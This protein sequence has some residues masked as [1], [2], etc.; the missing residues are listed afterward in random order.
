MEPMTE[1][2][3]A[4]ADERTAIRPWLVGIGILSLAINALAFVAP[5][6]M[7][8]VFDRVLTSGRI[9]TLVY[10]TLLA[11][12]ALMVLGI[13][14]GARSQALAR[15]GVWLEA[16]LSRRALSEVVNQELRHARPLLDVQSVRSFLASPAVT[17]FLDAPAVPLF[18]AVLWMIHPLFGAI[19]AGTAITL[20]VIAA[21]GYRVGKSP[22]NAASKHRQDA[23]GIA[24]SAIRMTD[25][26]RALGVLSHLLDRFEDVNA[27]GLEAQTRSADL[28]SWF[29]GFTKSF[30]I[31]IQVGILGVGAYLVIG[32]ELTGGGMIAASIMLGRALAPV[33]QAAGAWKG[34]AS[35][36]ASYRSLR[37]VLDAGMTSS[38]SMT[39]DTPEGRLAVEGLTFRSEPGSPFLI[40]QIT[41]ALEP[42]EQ[43]AII[44]PSASGKSLL[45]RLLTGVLRPSL[46]A[47]RLDGADLKDWN[48]E[49][50]SAAIGYLP[51]DVEL[52]PGTVAQNIARMDKDPDHE[53]IL[54]AAK[55]AGVHDLILRLSD[56]YDTEVG[57]GTYSLSGGQR[58]QIAIARAI[59]KRPSLV[60]MDEPNSNL[61]SI[62][63]AALMGLLKTLRRLGTTVVLVT[64]RPTAVVEMD[65]IMVV[66]N[67]SIERFGRREEVMASLCLGK[68]DAEKSIK[69]AAQEQKAG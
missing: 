33:E 30:R 11:G 62:G 10:L 24:E 38:T 45:C 18:I 15:L 65:K 1:K 17:G 12:A 46:G 44:G 60:V 19:S 3:G 26:V 4:L 53:A 64:H 61:D 21:I 50:I 48:P 20:V 29:S 39:L 34:L 63:D 7:M 13:L 36:A 66:R 16:R 69:E 49:Q 47:V 55:A 9:E 31:L 6:Y 58:Q 28:A 57:P 14:E 2:E 42:G 41:F 52:F 54:E 23:F 35:A 43:L 67:G 22:N 5:L 37:D 25:N 51:Q 56:A 40:K 8:Q 32:G 68:V 59:Y 27:K